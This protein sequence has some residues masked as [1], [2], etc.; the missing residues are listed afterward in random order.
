[1]MNVS[2]YYFRL[3]YLSYSERRKRE[4]VGVLGGFVGRFRSSRGFRRFFWRIGVCVEYLAF[5]ELSVECGLDG[6][7]GGSEFFV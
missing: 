3:V 7:V 6:A 4:D 1:M 2:C 5:S